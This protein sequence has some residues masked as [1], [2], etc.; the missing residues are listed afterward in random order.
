LSQCSQC[1]TT[2]HP[3]AIWGLAYT[4]LHLI[5]GAADGHLRIYDP[6][7]L[8]TPIH[9]IAANPLAISSLSTTTDGKYALST[10]LDGSVVL[11]D[12]VEGR[13]VGRVETGREKAAD[14]ESG[15]Y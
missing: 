1:L 12:A 9:N 10:S 5:S 13:V 14:G 7:S 11:V 8:S 6:Q 2:V 4:P 3:E 15:G